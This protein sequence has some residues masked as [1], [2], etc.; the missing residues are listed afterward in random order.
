VLL[1]AVPALRDVHGRAGLVFIDAHENAT[2]V[3][4]AYSVEAA[5]MEIAYLLGAVG[6]PPGES[7]PRRVAAQAPA[8]WLPIIPIGP[9]PRGLSRPFS[10]STSR[11]GF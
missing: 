10:C 4:L 9:A 3:H 2:P 1:G 7:P 11:G 8:W 5:N 6:E